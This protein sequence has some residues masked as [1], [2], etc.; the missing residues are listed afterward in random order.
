MYIHTCIS[1]ISFLLYCFIKGFLI[2]QDNYGKP[3]GFF[4]FFFKVNIIFFFLPAD[5]DNVELMSALHW[6]S[7]P[8]GL[9]DNQ[10]TWQ[11]RAK[12]IWTAL[13]ISEAG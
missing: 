13:K 8:P 9:C 12:N 5:K 4:F 7:R 10:F 1:Y 11:H 6:N 3:R 2:Q